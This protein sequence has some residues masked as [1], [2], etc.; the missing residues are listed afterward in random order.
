MYKIEKNVPIPVKCT[1]VTVYPFDQMKEGDSF[2]IPTK[3]EKEAMSKRRSVA[4]R[5][6]KKNIKVTTRAVQGG[7]R[8][9]RV[10]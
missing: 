7:I 3:T 8:V 1:R 2:L 4:V 5:A 10:A 9:W 6:K